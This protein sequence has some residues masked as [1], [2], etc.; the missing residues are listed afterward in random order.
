MTVED[1]ALATA[2]AARCSS[3]SRMRARHARCVRL[4]V[5]DRFVEHAEQDA[6]VARGGHRRRCDRRRTLALRWGRVTARA[7]RAMARSAM[8]SGPTEATLLAAHQH[9]ADVVR[10]SGSS[11]AAA[12]WMLPRPQRRALHA[13]YAFCRLADDIADDPARAGRS[14]AVARALARRARRGV[15]GAGDASG[16]A[17]RWPTRCSA[18]GCPQSVFARS[19]ARR[20][21]GSARRDDRDLRGPRALLL[22]RRLDGRPAAGA[23]ARR[24]AAPMRSSTRGRWASR[25]S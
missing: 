12:F 19:A 13:I 20:R 7:R 25:C 24:R 18:I 11:F 16:R 4:G 21:V 3:C 17:S 6:A 14:H 15:R 8:T 10:R 1:H 5:A 2:S 9:C 23:R 22:S